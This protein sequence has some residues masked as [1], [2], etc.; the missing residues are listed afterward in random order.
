MKA[1][2]APDPAKTAAA[3]GQMNK[4]TAIAQYGLN[5]TNQVTPYGNLS[6]S[7]IGNWA[8]GTPRYQATQTLSPDQQNILDSSERL[9]QNLTNLGVSQSERLGGLLST[10][11]DISNEATES[12]LM[13]LGRKRLD[14]A[15]QQRRTSTEQD[16]YNRG[17]RPGTEAYDRAMNTV[18]QGEND[19]YNELLL[20]GRS[21]AV[22]EA[23][24]QRT[25][26]INEILALASGGQVQNPNFVNTPG[27]QISP[28]DYQGAVNQKYQ[29][30][31]AQYQSGMSGLFGLGSAAIGG[32]AMSD[33]RLKTDKE[34]VGE[35]DDGIGVYKYRFKGSPMMQLGVMAQEVE[36]KKPQAVM[37][38]RSGY[39]AVNY[40]MVAGA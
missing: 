11:F 1:P 15:L 20:G 27:S 10:P 23:L 16:L 37:T 39:K 32:W 4:E 34:R 31:L 3:Q 5:A 26:P 6:Y 19:A 30:E 13:E 40:P 9:T 18:N 17:V 28:P 12:R 7:Q 35:T 8:D 24:M 22:Q 36:K 38:T 2:S 21:Q 29:S 25:Q 33:E 14:P